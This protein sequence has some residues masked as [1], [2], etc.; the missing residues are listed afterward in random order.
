MAA[1]QA[2]SRTRRTDR[3]DRSTGRRRAHAPA[4]A[5][6][7]TSAS[8]ARPVTPAFHITPNV[9]MAA[10][11]TMRSN[12]RERRSSSTRSLRRFAV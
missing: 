10:R 5:R 7:E 4:H 1:T 6:V 12:G 3:I 2:T 8:H 9:V 11:G